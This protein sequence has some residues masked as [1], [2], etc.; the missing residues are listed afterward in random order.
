MRN[1]SKP[2]IISELQLN[3]KR[4]IYITINA[5]S[6]NTEK[7]NKAV[8]QEKFDVTMNFD[9]MIHFC[10]FLT[11]NFGVSHGFSVNLVCGRFITF[12]NSNK[13]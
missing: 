4:H 6:I 7:R 5:A 13:I 3:L 1:R 9:M 10:S 11:E 2:I 8:L 12:K